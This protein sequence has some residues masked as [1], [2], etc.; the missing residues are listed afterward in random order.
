MKRCSSDASYSKDACILFHAITYLGSS[1]VNAPVSE[2]ELRRTISI[3][4]DHTEVSIGV[5]LAVGLTPH[6]D[7]RLIDPESRTDIASYKISSICFW[8]K[9]DSDNREKDCFA[10]NISHGKDDP[11][12]HCHV[13]QCSEED[14]VRRLIILC[15]S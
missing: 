11:T 1:T 12:F 3:L 14:A 5:I 2:I 6:S 10:F 8:G 9:G 4:R 7:V 13:F 15:E